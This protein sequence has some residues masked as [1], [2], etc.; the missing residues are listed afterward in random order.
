MK[1]A[2]SPGSHGG[3]TKVK[4]GQPS[5]HSAS[6]APDNKIGIPSIS[7]KFNIIYSSKIITHLALHHD[8]KPVAN[9]DLE[10]KGG[11]GDFSCSVGFSSFCHLFFFPQ[12]KG[13]GPSP[14]SATANCNVRFV[15]QTWYQAFSQ[16]LK[17][18]C[19][20]YAT[21]PAQMKNS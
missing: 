8:T 5:R 20:K 6:S 3:Q 1:S 10:L 18:G 21:G 12:N 7:N 4:D 15:E 11:G 14:K 19:P 9:P 13:P 16:D 2:C 17:S